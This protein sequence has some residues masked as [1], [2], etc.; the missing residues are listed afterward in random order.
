LVADWLTDGID[1]ILT[2]GKKVIPGNHAFRNKSC[3]DVLARITTEL[4]VPYA[5]LA[6]KPMA[7]AYFR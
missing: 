7:S 6:V 5:A 4:Q 1:L 3:K 2:F